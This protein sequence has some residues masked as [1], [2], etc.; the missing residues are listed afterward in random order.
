M[1]FAFHAIILLWYNP[2]YCNMSKLDLNVKLNGP[3][4]A[5]RRKWKVNFR[6][7][8]VCMLTCHHVLQTWMRISFAKIS[9]I[10]SIALT[11]TQFTFD[12]IVSSLSPMKLQAFYN[13]GDM[14]NGIF[15]LRITS[16]EESHFS[17]LYIWRAD[18]CRL[19][20]LLF[21]TC[22][23][24]LL[25]NKSCHNKPKRRFVH[26]HSLHCV[27]RERYIYYWYMRHIRIAMLV[28][29]PMCMEEPTVYN[30]PKS[31]PY[32]CVRPFS[33]EKTNEAKR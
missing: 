27:Q 2:R 7:V 10:L 16:A 30:W 15:V 1:Y 12:F 25:L 5:N 9:N 31:D 23:V 3:F 11:H 29:H 6:L 33:E 21:S 13:V 32:R 19:L 4:C 28:H 18:P 20:L 14:L 24:P 17:T 26:Y 22:F 8:C